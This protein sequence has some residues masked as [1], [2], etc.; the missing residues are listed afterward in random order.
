M[1]V[2]FWESM[3]IKGCYF[4]NLKKLKEQSHGHPI[5]NRMQTVGMLNYET[6]TLKD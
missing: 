2:S 3:R 1:H 6:T 5:E 4:Y